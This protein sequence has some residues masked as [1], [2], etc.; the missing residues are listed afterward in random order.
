MHGGISVS[1]Q[2]QGRHSQT[3][4]S[5]ILST[6]G[7]TASTTAVG[8]LV[9]PMFCSSIPSNATS[10]ENTLA[11]P[12]LPKRITRLSKTH[13]PQTSTGRAAPMNASAVTR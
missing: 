1:S 3:A 8:R 12:S 10:E 4:T 9:L 2:S 7:S 5:F 13:R 6:M 11:V